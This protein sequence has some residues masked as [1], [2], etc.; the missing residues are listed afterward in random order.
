MKWLQNILNFY[1]NSSVHVALSVYALFRITEQYFN[2]QYQE[3]LAYLIFYGTI[4]GYNFIKYAGV[5]KFYHR[6]LTLNLRIIQ[7]F[8][9]VC[10]CLMCYYAWLLPKEI[11]ILFIPFGL[12]TILYAVPFLAGFQ[13]SLREI[14]YLKVFLV[15]LVWS[16]VTLI[17]PLQSNHFIIDIDFILLAIQRLLFVV[18]LTLPFEIRDLELDFQNVKTLPHKIGVPQTKRLGLFLLLIALTIEFIT[19]NN[20]TSRNIFF[21]VCCV[22]LMLLMRAKTTQSKYYSSFWVESLPIFWWLVLLGFSN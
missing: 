12:I 21:G 9:F 6:S 22:L 5:A 10:F 4:T 18:A 7:I 20:L 3:E 1:I 14:S 11:L 17:I 19:N 15:A 2:L 16:G 13:K 8:S